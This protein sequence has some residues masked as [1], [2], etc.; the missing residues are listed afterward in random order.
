ML[1]AQA[2]PNEFRPFEGTF[3]STNMTT[4]PGE[5]PGEFGFQSSGTYQATHM[6]SGTFEAEGGIEYSVTSRPSMASADS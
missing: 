6:G 2:A 5:A 4:A 1:G 3:E